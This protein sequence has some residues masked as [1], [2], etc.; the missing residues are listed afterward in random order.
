MECL[1]QFCGIIFGFEIN[2]FSDHKNM[3]YAAT[4]S[5]YQR[6]IQWWLNIKEFG[7][8]IQHIYRVENITAY[9]LSILPY[10]PV[11]KYE[12]STSKAQCC[13]KKLFKTS[14]A[15]NNKYCFPLNWLKVQ[16]EQQKYLRKVNSKLSI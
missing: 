12:P 3:I 14:R 9:K 5:E 1:K 11:D 16:R 15:E 7:T 4:L 6:A 2:V 10:T 13:A 8:N